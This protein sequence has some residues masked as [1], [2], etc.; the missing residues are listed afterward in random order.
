VGH[1]VPGCAGKWLPLMCTMN[2]TG[3]PEEIQKAFSMSLM[4][5]TAL[6][7]KEPPGCEG[8]NI[9]PYFMG[10]RTPDWPQS[11]GSILGL[12]PGKLQRPGLLYRAALEGSTF[13]LATGIALCAPHFLH[14]SVC[15]LSAR[16]THPLE[17][18]ASLESVCKWLADA[19][20]R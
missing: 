10:E 18:E 14:S 16:T 3:C 9:L 13:S 6:A 2:C 1:S 8:V 19:H 7:T 20:T 11:K 5:A 4:E 15:E 17:S 12:T